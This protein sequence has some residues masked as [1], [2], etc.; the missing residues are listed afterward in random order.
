MTLESRFHFLNLWDE[1][2]NQSEGTD[3]EAK[4]GTVREH[5]SANKDTSEWRNEHSLSGKS[6]PFCCSRCVV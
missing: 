2:S 1:T 6:V 4:E 5:Q 3:E